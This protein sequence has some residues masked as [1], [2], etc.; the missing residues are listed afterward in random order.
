M[1]VAIDL[2]EKEAQTSRVALVPNKSWYS[3]IDIEWVDG[4]WY[5]KTEMEDIMVEV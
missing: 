2:W 1:Q 5:Y 3:L 4:E